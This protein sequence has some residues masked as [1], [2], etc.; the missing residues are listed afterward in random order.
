[1]HLINNRQ[2]EIYPPNSS[3]N[4]VNTE[5]MQNQAPEDIIRKC[6]INR[7]SAKQLPSLYIPEEGK[8]N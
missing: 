5:E 4:K 1:M 2:D 6:P 8:K 3:V 7:K